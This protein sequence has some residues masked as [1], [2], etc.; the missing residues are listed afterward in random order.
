MDE[1][2]PDDILAPDG[3]IIRLIPGAT[4]PLASVVVGVIPPRAD[5]YPVHLHYA[6]DQVTYVLRGRVTARSRRHGDPALAESTLEPGQAITTPATT[7]L[8]FR[9]EG[10]EPAEVLFICVPPYPPSNADTE[11]VGDEHRPLSDEELRL[12]AERAQRGRDYLSA[13]LDA[14]IAELRWNMPAEEPGRGADRT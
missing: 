13:I 5:D 7:T 3:I 14:R 2:R 1:R 4:T 12:A 6:L 11:L 9:N 10:S 8:S